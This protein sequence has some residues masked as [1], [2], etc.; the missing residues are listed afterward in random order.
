MARLRKTNVARGGV[1]LLIA[2]AAGATTLFG[3]QLV[4]PVRHALGPATVA[5][6]VRMGEGTTTV[7][8]P[9]LGAI[10]ADTHA[11]PLRVRVTIDEVDPEPLAE[12]VTFFGARRALAAEIEG[13]LRSA[14]EALALRVAVAGLLLGA[15]MAALLPGRS[16][17]T[18]AAGAAGG[19]IAVAVSIAA[20]AITFDVAAFEEPRF[21]GALRRA[22]Q[23]IKA[24][25]REVGTLEQLRSRFSV[26]ADRLSELLTLAADPARSP[27][28]GSIAILHV[29]DIH[30]NPVGVEITRELA[31]SFQVDAVLDTG[32]LTS[33]G[34]AV[35]GRLAALIEGIAVPYLFVPGNHDSPQNRRALAAAANVTV[36]DRET[37]SVRGVR[38]LGWADPTFTAT[39]EITTEEGNAI[40]S[41]EAEE[42]A[43]A[44]VAA[45]PDVLAVHDARLASASLGEVGAVIAGHTH[46]R[47]LELREGTV[48]ATVGSTGAT[49]L[50][51]FLVQADLRYEAQVLYLREDV[52][53]AIDYISFDGLGGDFTVERRSL[54]RLRDEAGAA[55]PL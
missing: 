46:R 21:T 2:V 17:G 24:V 15:I 33:F 10:E 19:A 53:V 7:H 11:S 41:A 35:E 16:R 52:L 32:D 3:I 37:V 43:R 13:D 6:G 30:S 54:E 29:S 12:A 47:S 38:I 4:P 23:V 27:R 34:E 28:E 55:A 40:R 9:P 8:V 51:S 39:N 20:T 18:I 50:G 26:M 49:G 42:V 14:A 1:F 31:E 48:V 22:P 36:L 44:V 5:A 25:N 45:R